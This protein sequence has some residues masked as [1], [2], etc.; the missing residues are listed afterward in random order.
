MFAAVLD[1]VI[2]MW[3]CPMLYVVDQRSLFN[4]DTASE[5]AEV[6]MSEVDLFFEHG[7]GRI[8]ALFACS[9]ASCLLLCCTTYD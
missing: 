1:H 3:C 2:D 9:M 7:F 8:N 6:V 5:C 4:G